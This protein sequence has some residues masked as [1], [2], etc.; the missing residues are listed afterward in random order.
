MEG[1]TLRLKL[2]VNSV[3]KVCDNEGNI[4]QEE[5]SLNAVYGANGTANAQWCKWTPSGTFQF[6][7][8]NPTAFGRLLPGQFVFADLTLTDKDSYGCPQDEKAQAV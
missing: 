6:A 5:I 8:S 1:A 2:Q 4:S 3:K 7:I